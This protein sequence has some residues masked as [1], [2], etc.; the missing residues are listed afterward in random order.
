[1]A[2]DLS[3]RPELLGSLLASAPTALRQRRRAFSSV[4][5]LGLDRAN[6]AGCAV[7][8]SETPK[9]APLTPDRAHRKPMTRSWFQRC[10]TRR[11]A[12]LPSRCGPHA[13]QATS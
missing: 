10:G 7:V 6:L 13:G 2:K 3:L 4:D 9:A 11:S 12:L 5:G 1:M 8:V